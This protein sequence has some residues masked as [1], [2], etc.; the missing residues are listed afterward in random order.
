MLS[1]N[2]ILNLSLVWFLFWIFINNYLWNY[3]LSIILLFFVIIF[4]LNIYLYIKNFL[5]YFIFIILFFLFWVFI[6]QNSLNKINSNINV[7][8][9]YFNNSRHNLELTILDVYKIKDYSSEF[10]AKVDKIDR[11]IVDTNIYSII[12][13]PSNYDIKIWYKILSNSKIKKIQNFNDFNYEKYL[14][15]K[16]I[17][18]TS[19]LYSLEVLDKVKKNI[20]LENIAKFRSKFL[21]TIYI[22]F[23]KQEAIFLW[24]ILLWARESLPQELKTNFN[25]SW[26]TH[27][28]AVSWFNI[29]ILI[30]FFS[31]IFK[32][33]PVFLRIILITIVIVVFT[34]LVWDTAPVLR[35]SIMWLLWYYIL[36]SWRKANILT[37][38]L[39]TAFFMVLIS[40]Y[41]L[42]Y[43]I[44]FH[45]SFLA[46]LWI[47]YTQDFFKKILFFLP[48]TLEIREAFVLTMSALS[49]S[50]PIMIFNFGQVSIL[51][52]IANIAVTWTIPMAMLLWFLSIIVYFIYPTLGFIIWY[53]DWILLK[54]DILMV[55]FF[56]TRDFALLKFNF[57]IYRN[58]LEIL[59]FIIL[60]F[61]IMYFRKNKKDF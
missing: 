41:I 22:I 45:L 19:Y 56:G 2:I 52:P 8:E 26:L 50:L 57:W 61:L 1:K 10:I 28:I 14:I 33:F 9:K 40:P 18:F 31:F 36:S 27:F 6:S 15:S 5:T 58:Y 49:F 21:K 44:S 16:N 54:W 55:N 12:E 35:A 60:I 42:N 11:H 34:L 43:D 46:V 4:W 48:E 25:N 20:I 32:I 51:S 59:Y 30:I 3:F 47:V 37:L 29:T 53:F 39:L 38:L 7:L 13:V 23:P 17:Y 24:W